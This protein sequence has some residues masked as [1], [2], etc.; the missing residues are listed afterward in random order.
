MSEQ[1]K[2]AAKKRSS[3]PS[4][5]GLLGNYKPLVTLLV[6][7]A[8]LTNAFNLWLPKIIAGGIDAFGEGNFQ[9]KV[10][11]IEFL[12]ATLVIFVF[13]WLQ[14]WVQTLVSERVARDLR[15]RL[16]EKIS[17]QSYA[18][19]IKSN[20]SK[21][22]TNLTSDID[23]IK[24]FVSHAFVSIISSVF[25]IIG[26][27]VLLL[28]TNWRLALPIIAIIPVI[29]I[30]F[31]MVLKKVRVLIKKSREVIDRLNKVINESILGAA[32]IRVLNAQQTEAH[33]FLN[34]NSQARDL[35]ISILML[36]ATL[37]PIIT[38]T[39]NLAILTILAFGGHLVITDNMS[40][41]DF[42]AF[43]SYLTI[44]IFPIIIIGFM[45]SLIAQA[46]ASFKRIN[47]VLSAHE[48]KSEGEVKTQLTGR[49]KLDNVQLLFGEKAA[50]KNL[51]LEVTPGS[52][53][54]IVG[55]TAAGKT[56][57]LYLLTGLATA[58][59]GTIAFDGTPIG[60]FEAEAF[61]RQVGLV[62][63]DSVMFNM[64]VRENV[65]FSD[66]IS[67]DDLKRAI[68]TAELSDFLDTLP[69]GIDTIVSE[70]GTSLSGGQKQR[71]MLARALALNPRILLLDDFT[72][73]VD[74]KT[75]QK[76]V[77]NLQ[78]HYPYLTLISVTQKIAPIVNYDQIAVLMEGELVAKGTHDTLMAS[79]PEY[80]Q[81]FNS[82]RS[83]NAYDL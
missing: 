4:L 10:V 3:G 45:S 31:Y 18:Y 57:L 53:T 48:P 43:N 11:V 25:V 1:H 54:A 42:A 6:T 2:A 9:P 61:Y 60:D 58:D 72:A 37:M 7:F 80:V 75:E 19:I 22:L 27:M 35:G 65:A 46:S 23:S 41:G 55:P 63:Q 56:Q 24:L 79:C 62:F 34:I 44:L 51:T 47:E 40:L 83:T 17:R 29:G 74:S 49:I 16:A 73:R 71:I 32:I 67:P 50:I 70:R 28:M 13:A 36:F 77:D 20:P 59:N 15:N 78:H 64:S 76:I 52:K 68:D 21:L 8:I 12:V 30:A 39:A 5:F 81:I 82:Q 33:K 14:N 66:D 38:F 69:N 26:A